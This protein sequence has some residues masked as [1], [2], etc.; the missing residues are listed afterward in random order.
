M[1]RKRPVNVE[2]L[3]DS[4][5]GYQWQSGFFKGGTTGTI[6]RNLTETVMLW[7]F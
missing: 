4:V 6:F 1:I 3:T 2:I 7:R 5:D